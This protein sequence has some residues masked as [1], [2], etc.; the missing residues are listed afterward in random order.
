M[1][2]VSNHIKAFKLHLPEDQRVFLTGCPYLTLNVAVYVQCMCNA[3]M[4]M[5]TIYY[6]FNTLSS[7]M[8][9][10]DNRSTVYVSNIQHHFGDHDLQELFQQVKKDRRGTP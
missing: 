8:Q 6:L 2:G 9:H 7:H 4:C 10:S 5:Y 1:G 3:C